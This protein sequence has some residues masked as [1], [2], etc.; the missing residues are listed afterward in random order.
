MVVVEGIVLADLTNEILDLVPCCYQ[1]GFL[2]LEELF[3][4]IL[5][6]IDL[7]ETRL[8]DEKEFLIEGSRGW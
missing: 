1:E 2:K 7:K 6:E 8:R 3:L 5:W 4:D